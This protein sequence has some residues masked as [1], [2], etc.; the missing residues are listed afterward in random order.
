MF[1]IVAD[2]DTKVRCIGTHHQGWNGGGEEEEEEEE[3]GTD[4]D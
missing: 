4:D 1:L 2:A 3:K